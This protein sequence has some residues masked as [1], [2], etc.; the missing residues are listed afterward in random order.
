MENPTQFKKTKLLLQFIQAKNEKLN[1]DALELM[2][3]KK[4]ALSVPF[5]LSEGNFLN[6]CVL[7]NGYWIKHTST[8][9]HTFTYQQM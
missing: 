7:F 6:I 8:N 2:K 4:S 1:C 3:E 9:T 5:I